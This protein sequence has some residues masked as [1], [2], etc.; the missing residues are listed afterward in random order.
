MCGALQEFAMSSIF[1]TAV[2]TGWITDENPASCRD[3]AFQCPL[4]EEDAAA[5][6][7]DPVFS[8]VAHGDTPQHSVFLKDYHVSAW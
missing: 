4:D 5:R 6:I 8:V 3:P 1:M 7:L 2:D